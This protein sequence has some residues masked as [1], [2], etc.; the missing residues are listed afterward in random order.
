ML[1]G[2]AIRKLAV[3]TVMIDFRHGLVFSKL[4]SVFVFLIQFGYADAKERLGDQYGPLTE[5]LD[6]LLNHGYLV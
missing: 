4:L 6:C 2:D 5:S 1:F 3:E